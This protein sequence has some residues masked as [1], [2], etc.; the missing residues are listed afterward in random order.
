MIEVLPVI[1][2]APLLGAVC[3][4]LVQGQGVA[5]EVLSRNCRAVGMLTTGMVFVLSVLLYFNDN[6]VYIVPLIPDIYLNYNLYANAFSKY[7]ILGVS[8]CAFMTVWVSYFSKVE[9][10]RAFIFTLL[11][12]EFLA[13]NI[14]LTEN[15]MVLVMLLEMAFYVIVLQVYTINDRRGAVQ[16]LILVILSLM[17]MIAVLSIV[18]TANTADISSIAYQLPY[19][20][21]KTIEWWILLI[22]FMGRFPVFIL[23]GWYRLLIDRVNLCFLGFV[24]TYPIVISLYA[25]MRVHIFA[26][27]NMSDIYANWVIWGAL[28]CMAGAWGKAV[29]ERDIKHGIGGLVKGTGGLVLATVFMLNQDSAILSTFFIV[30]YAISICGLLAVMS[31]LC[32]RYQSTIINDI[33]HQDMRVPGI[34]LAGLL[35]MGALSFMPFTAGFVSFVGMLGIWGA[36]NIWLFVGVVVAM[37][38]ASVLCTYYYYVV[39]FNSGVSRNTDIIPLRKAE[40]WFIR[41]LICIIV[42]QGVF[43]LWFMQP[44]TAYMYTIGLL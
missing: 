43:P 37:V 20:R 32:N 14:F 31:I 5:P 39:F 33:V 41:S 11:V 18:F 26:F 30:S 28:L 22:S 40:Y 9:N 13:I 38:G 7:F 16:L 35:C 29:W 17:S 23:D 42:I 3:A 27:G 25:I 8:L 12:L 19:D 4:S 34:L 15:I 2:F 36:Y 24:A 10:I 21:D 44:L 6:S 1:I